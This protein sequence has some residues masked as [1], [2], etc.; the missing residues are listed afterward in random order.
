M[1]SSWFQFWRRRGARTRTARPTGQRTLPSQFRQV[2]TPADGHRASTR[3]SA[4][5][6]VLTVGKGLATVWGRGRSPNPLQP[7][8]V[9]SGAGCQRRPVTGASTGHLA[10]SVVWTVGKGLTPADAGDGTVPRPCS[11]A[12]AGSDATQRSQEHRP[13]IRL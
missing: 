6:V 9:G 1:V 3:H 10:V 4:A 5:S 11:P 12:S 7:V 13:D 2:Q 8:P